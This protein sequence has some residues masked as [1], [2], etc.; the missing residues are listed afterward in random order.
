MRYLAWSRYPPYARPLREHPGMERAHAPMT[1]TL[2]LAKEDHEKGGLR[3]VLSQDKTSLA[4]DEAVTLSITCLSDGSAIPCQATSARVFVPEDRPE[5]SSLPSLPLS[6]TPSPSGA[7]VAKLQPKRDYSPVYHGPLRISVAIEAGEER[8]AASFDVDSTP[9]PPLVF[10]GDVRETLEDGSL[11]FYVSSLVREAGRYRLSARVA[12]AAHEPFA[13]LLFDGELAPG[14]REIPFRL[15]GRLARDE[16][17]KAPFLLQDISG[18]LLWEDRY[19]DR[20]AIPAWEGVI[21]KSTMIREDQL[22]TA[23]WQSDDKARRIA[24][25]E[26]AL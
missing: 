16:A 14:R 26:G 9:E 19:P 24:A 5:S 22:S 10:T 20:A 21:Y 12:S 1:R 17:A 25:L 3:V 4:G 18:Y 15:A 8:G 2:P 6:F 11:T 23:E 13:L 7:L